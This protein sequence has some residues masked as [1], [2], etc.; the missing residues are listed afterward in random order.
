[1]AQDKEYLSI[2]DQML[3]S[4]MDEADMNDA[5][6]RGDDLSDLTRDMAEDGSFSRLTASTETSRTHIAK[7]LSDDNILDDVEVSEREAK[8]NKDGLAN[9]ANEKALMSAI[10]QL[11]KIGHAPAKIARAISKCAELNLDNKQFSTNYLNSRS[12]DLGM[13]Y[14]QP[15]TFMPKQP[16]TYESQKPKVSSEA[17]FVINNQGSIVM[18]TPISAEANAWVAENI[19][20]DNGYQPYW[21]TVV[22][23]A[24]YVDDILEGIAAEGMVVANEGQEHQASKTGSVHIAV[25]GEDLLGLNE[26]K[27]GGQASVQKRAIELRTDIKKASKGKDTPLMARVPTTPK[28]QSHLAS[29][30]EEMVTKSHIAGEFTADSIEQFSFTGTFE[31]FW[32]EACAKY[33]LHQASKA[34]QEFLGRAKRAGRKFAAA[35]V[36]FFRE[37]LGFTG[38]EVAPAKSGPIARTAYDSGKQG[39]TTK[40]G[41]QLL[42]EFGLT[43]AAAPADIEFREEGSLDVEIKNSEINL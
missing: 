14:L 23:E 15:N 5:S 12:N 16:D 33:G 8:S 13:G 7:K 26:S 25:E 28:S 35:D 39:G 43:T 30:A 22:L 21:P 37:K 1:M 18:L 2:I 31:K 3:D 29:D 38:I 36:T 40:D 34:T 24:R 11:L 41:N 20:Q 17:D 10:D 4:G 27:F 32:N 9:A 42:N 19:G 6:K